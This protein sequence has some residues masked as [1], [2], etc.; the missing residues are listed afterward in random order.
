MLGPNL[1]GYSGVSGAA[2]NIAAGQL[3][4]MISQHLLRLVP[5]LNLLRLMYLLVPEPFLQVLRGALKTY[6]PT[7]PQ[8]LGLALLLEMY[9][10]ESSQLQ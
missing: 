10:L 5:V 9:T 7:L 4:Q 1:I 6:M 2:F 8:V 3:Y